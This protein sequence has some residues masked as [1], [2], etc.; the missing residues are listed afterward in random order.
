VEGVPLGGDVEGVVKVGFILRKVV[1]VNS[2]LVAV[3]K[4]D[5][6]FVELHFGK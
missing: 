4:G 2:D 5:V 1:V 6:G 3:G